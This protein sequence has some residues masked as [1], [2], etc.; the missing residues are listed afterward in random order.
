[1]SRSDWSMRGVRGD[2]RGRPPE[3]CRVA[4]SL[5][6]GEYPRLEDV[7]WLKATHAI[8]A[9]MSLQNSDDLAGKGLRLDSLLDEYRAQGV[10]FRHAPVADNDVAG[11]GEMLPAILTAL[12]ELI[13]AGHTVLVHCNAGYNRAPTVAVAYLHARCGLSLDDA[14]ALV[15]AGRPC[16][17]FM[18]LLARHFA[19][20]R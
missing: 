7:A 11:L 12:D 16:V 6:V 13:V 4:P 5:Y 2:T 14:C 20:P 3:V 18:S 8:S 10:Q 1:M 19:P 15:K 17:P 9:V